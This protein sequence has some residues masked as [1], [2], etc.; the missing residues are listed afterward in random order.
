MGELRPHKLVLPFY[1]VFSRHES[2]FEWARQRLE[3]SGRTIACTSERFEFV[4]TDY[5][6]REMGEGLLKQ[7]W[8]LSE[9]ADAADLPDWKLESN[10]WE[11]EFTIDNA[12]EPRPLNIDPGYIT[13][14]KL[15]LATT[16]DRDHRLY[17]RDGILAEVTTYYHRGEWRSRPWTYPDYATDLCREF[18]T[19]CRE[20]L[21]QQ[22]RAADKG[23]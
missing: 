13:E 1:A 6:Q 11:A 17:L 8:A 9:L 20:R 15:V 10:R 19:R 21:R 23:K 16:K 7:F 2:A 5:Y 3:S 14:A 22:L 18:L 4:Q 12:G